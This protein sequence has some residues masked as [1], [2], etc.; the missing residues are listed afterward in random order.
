MRIMGLEEIT[1]GPHTSRLH[2]EHPVY[3]YL[4]KGLA[5]VKPD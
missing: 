2:P 5:I 1:P 4:L 3:S